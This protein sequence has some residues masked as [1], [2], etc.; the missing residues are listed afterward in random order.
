MVELVDT[1][2]SKSLIFGCVGSIPTS[3]TI[4]Y[5]IELEKRK[6]ENSL[7][8][9]TN[10][11]KIII[12]VSIYLSDGRLAPIPTSGTIKYRIELEKRKLEKIKATK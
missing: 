8:F 7:F 2:D 12:E 9:T 6:L 4:K 11:S 1:R 3:G 10:R 5:R